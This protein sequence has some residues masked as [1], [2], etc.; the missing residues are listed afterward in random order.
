MKRPAMACDTDCDSEHLGLPISW[1]EASNGDKTDKLEI[2]KTDLEP[3]TLR[4]IEEMLRQREDRFFQ[5][6]DRTLVDCVPFKRSMGVKSGSVLDLS[7]PV[8]SDQPPGIREL[9]IETTDSPCRGTKANMEEKVRELHLMTRAERFGPDIS[10]VTSP[11]SPMPGSITLVG[12]LPKATRWKCCCDNLANRVVGTGWF[13]TIA[14]VAIFAHC[15][16]IGFQIEY[17]AVGAESGDYNLWSLSFLEFCQRGFSLLFLVEL[18]LRLAAEGLPYFYDSPHLFWNYLDSLLVFV[19]IVEM[20]GELITLTSEANAWSDWSLLS[21]IRVIRIVRITRILRILRIV[22]LVRFVRSLRNLVSSIAMTMRSLGWSVVLLII[23]IYMFGI[24]ITDGVTDYILQ[25]EGGETREALVK[26][27]G[28]VHTAMHT[29][30]RSISNGISW[31]IVV[32]PL[33]E[34][35]WLWGYVF[36][37]YIVFTLF[38][39]LNVI[40]AVFCQSTIEGAAR[41]KEM[42]AE[43]HL[44]NRERY[45]LLVEDL[46]QNLKSKDTGKVTLQDF[47]QR[48]NDTEVRAGRPNPGEL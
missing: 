4:R 27:F 40:T 1:K 3:M 6:L 5:R 9:V 15:A 22:R 41:D 20:L 33:I 18:C 35:G 46:F 14:M 31:D 28:S 43:S 42:L 26:Y 16:L 10:R 45:Y 2:D 19:S 25:T 44:L 39:V 7:L 11:K 32:R 24:L 13:E 47:E 8:P 12:T 37:L 38:A 29:L 48:F 36:S 34:V 21:N 17:L 23:I 30:F